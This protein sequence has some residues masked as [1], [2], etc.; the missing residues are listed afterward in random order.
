[1]ATLRSTDLCS[2]LCNVCELS[3]KYANRAEAYRLSVTVR[4]APACWAKVTTILVLLRKPQKNL[5]HAL[6]LLRARQKC[7]AEGI[8]ELRLAATL[9]A[10]GAC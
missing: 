1:M 9:N 4:R 8:E 2:T 3:K 5:R 7:L 6:G 10:E